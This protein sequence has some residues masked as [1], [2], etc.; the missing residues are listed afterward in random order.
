MVV[1]EIMDEI[2]A[3]N[4]LKPPFLDVLCDII[5]FIIRLSN[6]LICQPVTRYNDTDM[7]LFGW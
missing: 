3:K 1:K 5:I 4:E 6:L 2:K 7:T